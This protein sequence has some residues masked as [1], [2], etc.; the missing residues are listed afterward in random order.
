[1][2]ILMCEEG[3]LTWFGRECDNYLPLPEVTKR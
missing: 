1:M 2:A 3:P